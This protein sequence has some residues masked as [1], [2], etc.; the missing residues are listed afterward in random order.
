MFKHRM[1]MT[2]WAHGISTALLPVAVWML[3]PLSAW[4]IVAWLGLSVIVYK[5]L[6]LAGSIGMH[7]L[8]SHKAFET[9]RTWE[10]ILALA[11]SLLL[12]GSPIQWCIAHRSHHKYHDTPLD[13]HNVRGWR[14]MFL[15]N[16]AVSQYD[17]RHARHLIGDRFHNW[18]HRN[19]LAWIAAFITIVFLIG[20]PFGLHWFTLM[21]G[22]VVPLSFGLWLG[23]LH[24]V[25]AHGNP[26]GK[27]A[28]VN[29]PLLKYGWGEWLHEN[30]HRDPRAWDFGKNEGEIDFGAAVVRRIL[31]K[32]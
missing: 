17:Y 5:A 23:G 12:I 20:L 10:I 29:V 31:R 14:S 2:G 18:L 19:Y 30:H 27:R 9:S 4:G 3:L 16:Y 8:F 1:A 21:F 6:T 24:N 32:P 7:R 15:S 11:G 25:I 13:P 28:P 22:F 26:H